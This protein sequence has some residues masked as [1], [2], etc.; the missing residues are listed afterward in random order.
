MTSSVTIDPVEASEDAG[1]SAPAEGDPPRTYAEILTGDER[2]ESLPGF[3]DLIPV[4][5]SAAL[6]KAGFNPGSRN[7]SVALLSGAEVQSLNKAFRGKDAATNVLSFP[8]APAPRGASEP[9]FLGDVALSYDTVIEEAAAQNK[10]ALNHAAHLIVHGVLHLAG[11]DHGNDADAEQM[12]DAE[13]LILA[14]YGIPD[15]YGDD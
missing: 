12:E 6:A 5:V 9:H 2:W 11:L 3:K 13:R 8:A 7:V 15:P 4:L 1:D 14:E 10:P